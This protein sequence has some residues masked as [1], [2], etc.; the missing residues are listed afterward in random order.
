MTAANGLDKRAVIPR[1]RT[2]N[3]TRLSGELASVTSRSD[4]LVKT[5]VSVESRE[6]ELAHRLNS[7]RRNRGVFEAADVINAAFVLGVDGRPEVSIVASYILEQE[8]A[9]ESARVLA[10]RIM[11]RKS[12]RHLHDM[13]SHGNVSRVEGIEALRGDIASIRKLLRVEP[14]N[15]I[16]WIDIARCY[17]SLGQDK[18]AE[19]AIRMAVSIAGDN[20]FIARSAARFHLH[21]DDPAR[22]HSL[23]LNNSALQYDPWILAAEVAIADIAG[24][25]VRNFRRA[26][27]M[28]ESDLSPRHVSELASALAAIELRSGRHKQA[29]RLMRRAL[30]DPNDNALA[31]AEWSV[32]HGIDVVDPEQLDLPNGFEARA[33][34]SLRTGHFAQAVRHGRRWLVDQPFALDAALFVTYVAPLLAEDFDSAVSAGRVGLLTNPG[35][36]HLINNLAFSLINNGD[37]AEASRILTSIT[38]S[39]TPR[40]SSIL[41]ATRGLLSYRLGEFDRGRQQYQIAI[42]QL[43]H[44]GERGLA[45]V[46]AIL[47]SREEVRCGSRIAEQAFGAADRL[48]GLAGDYPDAGLLRARFGHMIE[49][50]RERG[51]T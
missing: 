38:G 18:P 44:L 43:E 49:E 36:A 11:K 12:S 41:E 17:T 2:W 14:R 1:W 4:E 46:A 47:W 42:G 26:S 8:N 28:L 25:P 48:S 29:R 51:F 39:V 22:A 24:K 50:Y 15:S 10:N 31:Q 30:L 33:L 6:K 16:K 9:P 45:A 37:L 3:V 20:R 5:V 35:N 21:V 13:D 7:F 23:L 32:Q 19:A 27:K 40:E 34:Y